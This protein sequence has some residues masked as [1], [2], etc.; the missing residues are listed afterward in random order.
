MTCSQCGADNAGDRKF[1]RQC[2]GRLASICGQCGRGNDPGDRFCGECGASLVPGPA[3]QT[4]VPSPSGAERRL[5][6]VFFADLVGFTPFSE[7]R[8]AED[9]RTMLTDYFDRCR[10]VIEKFGGT[11]DKFIGDAVMAV[12]GAVAAREDDAERAVRA[13]LELV[14]AVRSLADHVGTPDLALRAGVM[15]GE[16]SVGPGGNAMGLV[17]GDM[18]NTASRLQSIAEPGTVLVGETTVDL[19]SQAILYRALGEQSVKGKA[20]AVPA[21]QATGIA[22]RVGGVARTEAVEP[23]FVGRDHEYRLLK[24]QLAAVET[25]GRARL[26]SLVGEAGIGKSRLAWELKKYA[27]GLVQTTYWHQGRS[28][29]YGDGLTFWALG[30]MVRGRAG[31][32]ESDDEH[33]SRTKLRTAVIEFCEDPSEQ[34]WIEPR[35]AGLLGLAEMPPGDRAELFA[36]L[37]TFFQRIADRGPMVMV[38]EDL[39]WADDGMVEFVEELV[40]RATRSPILVITLSRPELFDRHPGWGSTQRHG[41][42]VSLAPLPDQAMR[43]LVTGTAPVLPEEVVDQVVLRAGGIPL[44]AVEFIRMH[45]ADPDHSETAIPDSL[46]ALIG[47]RIDRLDP[48]LRSLLQDAAVLGLTFPADALARLRGEPIGTVSERLRALV[49]REILELEEDPRSPERGQFRFVQG[50]IREVAYARLQRAERRERHLAVAAAFEELDDPE[51]AGAIASHYLAAHEA[52]PSQSSGA[53]LTRARRSLFEAARRAMA[54]QSHRQTLGLCR[55]ALDIEAATGLEKELH[56]MAARAASA[57]LEKE[58]AIHHA[59]RALQLAQAEDD[60]EVIVAA[61]FELGFV[62]NEL[63]DTGAV[64]VLEPAYEALQHLDTEPRVLLAAE[65]ARSF[66][67]AARFDKILPVIDRALAAAEALGMYETIANG[68]ATKGAALGYSGRI[69][70]AIALLHGAIGIAEAHELPRVAARAA[71][72][73]AIELASE[74]WY[75]RLAMTERGVEFAERSGEEEYRLR[76]RHWRAQTLL[77]FGHV[78]QAMELWAPDEFDSNDT[79]RDLA[80]YSRLECHAIRGSG[81]D[82]ERHRILLDRLSRIDGQ[83]QAL[84]HDLDCVLRLYS[85]DLGGAA[86]RAIEVDHALPYP[87]GI[88]AGLFAAITLKDEAAV[89]GLALKLAHHARS[90][91]AVDALRQSA[92]AAVRALA[93]DVERAASVFGSAIALAQRVSSGLATSAIEAAFWGLVGDADPAAREAGLRAAAWIEGTGCHGLRAFWPPLPDADAHASAASAG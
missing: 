13:A 80:E 5:V 61:T 15:S 27:D 65:Y 81:Y 18:V 74:N 20:R 26:V 32:A 67:F 1:C 6:T 82:P 92:D 8:D 53:L 58:M 52:D 55:Q 4:E 66:I 7:D 42:S 11:V 31:I 21:W 41:M 22:A 38:F 72:N 49:K 88:E 59:R 2:G 23:P 17:V 84:S 56:G 54:L 47:A 48:G 85:G 73:L 10:S 62:M 3:L 50:L 19:T 40:E 93:G 36:A 78:D 51:V 45:Q 25:E 86:E 34:R 64:A 79:W 75:E 30:E 76:M 33:R 16:T 28:P 87:V 43:E 24:D 14:D 60:G 91:S 39:H 57:L 46:R 9:V 37:R 63:N 70:E 83:W 12:W 89:R 35:L 68:F 71:N 44:Y 69:Q 77:N 90:A 29:S